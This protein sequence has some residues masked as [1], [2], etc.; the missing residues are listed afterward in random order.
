M[1]IQLLSYLLL[2]LFPFSVSA[3]FGYGKISDIE[4][5]QNRKL[6][7]ITE[8]PNEKVIKKLNKKN[9]ADKI[10]VYQ[11]AIEEYNNNMKMIAEKFWWYSKNGIEYKT[12]KEADEL[13]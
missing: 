11:H 1:K 9:H 13:R 10:P 6:I 8:S 12:F 7:V 4:G 3:Q 2:L 5:V